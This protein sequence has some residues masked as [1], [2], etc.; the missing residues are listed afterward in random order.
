MEEENKETE[1]QSDE[2]TQDLRL[3]L[4][5]L[6]QT[7]ALITLLV[8]KNIISQEEINEEIAEVQEQIA[9]VVGKIQEI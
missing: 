5:N 2:P 7:K 8:K 9:Q 4:E 3:L 6:V 1:V